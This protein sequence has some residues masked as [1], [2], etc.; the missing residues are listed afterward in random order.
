MALAPSYRQD[1]R[2]SLYRMMSVLSRAGIT[3]VS[4]VEVQNSFSDL[5][6]T[7]YSISFLCD[8]LL[9]LRYVEIDSTLRRALV[10]IKM[11]KGEHSKDFREFRITKD[12]IEIEPSRLTG[13]RAL[14]TGI[15]EASI[16]QLELST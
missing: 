15:P 7:P 10:V 8:D 2:E 13:Y 3:V 14:S 9:R 12:T 4:T 11:R 16:T 6:F 5:N 1:F